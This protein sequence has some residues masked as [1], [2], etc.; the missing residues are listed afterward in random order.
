MRKCLGTI[1]HLEINGNNN[2]NNAVFNVKDENNESQFC[3]SYSN[4]NNR[5][6]FTKSD[7]SDDFDQQL[8]TMD[9]DDGQVTVYNDF[10]VINDLKVGSNCSIEENLNVNG[11]L[12]LNGNFCMPNN[13]SEAFQG[14]MIKTGLECG[15]LV[16]SIRFVNYLCEGFLE[17]ELYRDLP[18][19]YRDCRDMVMFDYFNGPN[20][21]LINGKAFVLRFKESCGT[22]EDG[23][24]DLNR[25]IIFVPTRELNGV[26]SGIEVPNKDECNTSQP[27]VYRVKSIDEYTAKRENAGLSFF[28]ID[29]NVPQNANI[30]PYNLGVNNLGNNNTSLSTRSGNANSIFGN[31]STTTLQERALVYDTKE[32][33][34]LFK[35]KVKLDPKAE[36]Q[37]T[38]I[39]NKTDGFDAKG[40]VNIDGPT[41]INDDLDV[42]GDLNLD[43]NINGNSEQMTMGLGDG[44]SYMTLNND[45]TVLKS[46]GDLTLD[47]EDDISLKANNLDLCNIRGDIKLNDETF[48]MFG[49]CGSVE[50]S[51]YL[52][53]QN[54]LLSMVDC[55]ESSGENED[56]EYGLQ[57]LS[58]NKD[59]VLHPRSENTNSE[60]N[61]S[62][63]IKGD[64]QC[65][66][67]YAHGMLSHSD[68]T[69]KTDINDMEENA[70]D[71]LMKLRPVSYKWKDN[72]K[73]DMGFL[74]QQVEEQFPEFVATDPNGI[75]G[76]DYSK[77]VSVL[78]K[79]LQMQQEKINE[80]MN[81]VATMKSSQ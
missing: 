62:V 41:H 78:T 56:E 61:G 33:C 67:F 69:L 31:S 55:S 8:L 73:Q 19:C 20:A 34:W 81:T 12:F 50:P 48:I 65:V 51:A 3:L 39:T 72:K 68:A 36:L 35:G 49:S 9:R 45:N 44:K 74:A 29:E 7:S 38:R 30:N 23:S 71:K 22:C 37:V 46:D 5:L 47:A 70:V 75:K 26:R 59:I 77:I 43:G 42:D 2:R 63:V 80:L 11:Q 17:I 28:F 40:P 10:S 14:P 79:G 27:A 1:Q 21:H 18:E 58:K 4:N 24:S 54:S 13:P 32:D 66:N 52:S 60:E 6:A 57:L 25:K 16:E 64:L 53:N 15:I 76:V